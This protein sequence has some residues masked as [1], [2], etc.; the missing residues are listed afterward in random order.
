MDLPA[1]VLWTYG[2][3]QVFA[4]NFS[5]KHPNLVLVS[6]A[7]AALPDILETTPF[8]FYLWI[9]RRRLGLNRLRDIVH[10]A[11]KIGHE[12]PEKFVAEF[13]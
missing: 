13:P 6:L 8:L 11:V 3:G 7:S 5:T 2:L 1:H 4:N 10:F 12:K 9:K